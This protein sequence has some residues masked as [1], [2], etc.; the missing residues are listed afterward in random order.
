MRPIDALRNPNVILVLTIIAAS[1]L[2]LAV[3]NT[4]NLLLWDEHAYLANARALIAES[5]YAELFRFPL[6]G[7]L[8]AALWTI[9]GESIIAAQLLAITIT[10]LTTYVFYLVARRFSTRY[11]LLFTAL[12]AFSAPMIS[13]GSRIYTDIGAVLFALIAFYLV[14][15]S[16][17]QT[18]RTVYA[19]IA[20]GLSFLMRYPVIIIPLI[21]GA[22]LIITKRYRAAIL[23][24]LGALI[25]IGPWM[26]INTILTGNPLSGL[27]DQATI[28]S[29]YYSFQSPLVYFEHIAAALSI[30]LILIIG[31]LASLRSN[32]K[33]MLL[34]AIIISILIVQSAAQIKLARYVITILPLLLIAIM[35]GL[36]H[37]SNLWP[38][39][40]PLAVIIVI[41]GVLIPAVATAQETIDDI[42]CTSAGAMVESIEYAVEQIPKGTTIVSNAWVYYG[43]H[44]NLRAYATWTDDVDSLIESHDPQYLIH[45]R[46]QGMDVEKSVFDR[47]ERLEPIRT[48]DDA[49]GEIVTIYRVR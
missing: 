15:Q 46:H 6:L 11:A 32:T 40:K 43:Y 47:D 13:W 18:K 37:V 48:F 28:V 27:I 20:G 26:I 14:L 33:H 44:A 30:S 3:I 24:V 25:I 34:L 23:M 41:A 12:F 17:D 38:R 29:E 36:E 16:D 21:A 5:H 22:Y 4:S 49:C 7:F 45:S 19:G 8:I 1:A 9:T 10:G 35:I 31:Y 42:R 39:L 2:H